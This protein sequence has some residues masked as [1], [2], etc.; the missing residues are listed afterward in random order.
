M[1]P[2]ERARVHQQ[3]GIQGQ[4]ARSDAY[5]FFNVLTGAELFEAVESL[6]PEHRERLFPPT[7]VLSMFLAQALSTDRSCQSAVN[8]SAV[9]RLVGG[10]P[11]CSTHTGGYCRARERLPLSMVAALTRDSGLLMAA[12]V[13][14]AWHWQGRPVRLVDGTTVTMPDTPANQAD[15]P[16]P[17]TQKP[18]LGFPLARLVGILC[19]GSGAIL[20]AAIG[21]YQGKGSDEQTL[22]RSMLDNL[23]AGDILL[24]DA[25]FAS[26]FLLSA[27]QARGVDGVFEQNGQRRRRTDFRRGQHLGARDH[28]ITYKK[29]PKPDWMSPA[30]YAA[31][32]DT[33]TVRELYADGR[34]LVTTLLCPKQIA[35]NALKELYRHRW[36]IELDLRNIKTT[37]GMERLSCK[38]PAMAEKELWVYLLAYNLIRL[39]MAQAA[40]H[41]GR[42]PRELS[43]KHTLQLWLVWRQQ[44]LDRHHDEHLSL[45]FIQIGQQRVGQRP[46]RR[47]PRAVKR[48]PKQFPLLMEPR[49]TAKANLEKPPILGKLSKC[50]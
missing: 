39:L 11:Q 45:F 8:E 5:T 14:Q 33:L 2:N 4:A 20:D 46:G 47:E 24:G 29:P 35:K 7:E 3:R 31:A 9:K 6:L 19:L 41:A 40:L 36:H 42:L 12:R 49:A 21:R 1:H 10:L 37:L 23:T 48:R 50:H 25:L 26:Y 13:P 17:Q 28:L 43:F 44:G 15:Y 22:L 32:P 27:L 34:I 18:G 38:T 30:D 16:Q